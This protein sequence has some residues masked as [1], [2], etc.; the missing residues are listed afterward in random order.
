VLDGV[1]V[2]D[3]ELV[4]EVDE[5]DAGVEVDAVELDE[6]GSAAAFLSAVPVPPLLSPLLPEGGLSL[7]E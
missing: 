6:A 2:V 7:S 5:L 3:D 4:V 1:A